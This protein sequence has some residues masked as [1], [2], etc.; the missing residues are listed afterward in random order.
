[1]KKLEVG[2]IVKV[3][4]SFLNE[5]ANVLA[6]VYEVYFIDKEPGVCIITQNGI[7]CGGFSQDEIDSYLAFERHSGIG[8]EFK[9]VIH[10]DRDFETKIK[11]AFN[12]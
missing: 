9:N 6:F 11:P 3:K 7:N 5:P 12:V 1:M 10:L 4:T 8:Y 2:D